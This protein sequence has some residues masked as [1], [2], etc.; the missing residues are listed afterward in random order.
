MFTGD[1][2][3]M[4]PATL[5]KLGMLAAGSVAQ[6]KVYDNN[7]SEHYCEQITSDCARKVVESRTDSGK[8]GGVCLDL[9]I[10][11]PYVGSRV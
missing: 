11:V 6:A 4:V 8:E 10:C 7:F 2:V 5:Q 1:P 3:I 9:I